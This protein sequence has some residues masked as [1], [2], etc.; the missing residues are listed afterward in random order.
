MYS[1]HWKNN[2]G[3]WSNIYTDEKCA[4][5]RIKDLYNRRCEG[6]AKNEKGEVVGRSREDATQQPSWNWFFNWSNDEAAA[7]IKEG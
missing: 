5:G 7:E 1:V 6:F 4:C 3:Q 2:Y